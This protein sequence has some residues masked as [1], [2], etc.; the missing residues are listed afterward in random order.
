[1]ELWEEN[2]AQLN[3]DLAKAEAEDELVEYYLGLTPCQ[4][5]KRAP[6]SQTYI[7]NQTNRQRRVC[8]RCFV[9]AWRSNIIL[10]EEPIEGD[11]EILLS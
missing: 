7:N 10:K 3:K 9:I 6:V 4:D 2:V 5:C 11:N 8:G 1:M